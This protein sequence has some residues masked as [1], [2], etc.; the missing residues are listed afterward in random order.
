MLINTMLLGRTCCIY[1]FFSTIKREAQPNS[2]HH[3]RF[4]QPEHFKKIF[5]VKLSGYVTSISIG[6]KKHL[7]YATKSRKAKKVAREG[8]IINYTCI[9]IT[10]CIATA[11]R[12]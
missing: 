5:V 2:T 8:I 9:M 10:D 6:W 1:V 3:L 12:C 11:Q 7:K 4:V